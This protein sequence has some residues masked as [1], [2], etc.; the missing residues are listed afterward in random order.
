ML[1]ETRANDQSVSRIAKSVKG[2]AFMG[3]PFGGSKHAGWGNYFRGLVDIFKTTDKGM[4]KDLKTDS[5]ALDN[6]RKAFLSI[7]HKR[8]NDNRK[9]SMVFFWEKYSLNGFV[10]FVV[11]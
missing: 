9:I 7:V 2:I 11:N 4:V 10:R 1:G 3:T 8:T 6:L 5:V